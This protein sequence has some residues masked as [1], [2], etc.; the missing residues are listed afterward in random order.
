[1]NEIHFDFLDN[2]KKDIDLV[3]NWI[4]AE[5]GHLVP[6]RTYQD[7]CAQFHSRVNENSPPIHIF[8]IAGDQTVGV[9]IIKIQEIKKN[10]AD[11]YW[12]GS[13]VVE[14]K[15]R[16]TGIGS[17][18]AQEV[19]RIARIYANKNFICK[20]NHWTVDCTKSWDGQM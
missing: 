9:A 1:M 3:A 6:N 13:L 5:W 11:S 14:P 16:G 20:L 15:H 18:L 4:Y 7:L 12:L 17:K 2:R 19:C 10:P 8:A